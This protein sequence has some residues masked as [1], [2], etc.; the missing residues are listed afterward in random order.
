MLGKLRK[1]INERLPKTV[2]NAFSSVGFTPN[3]ATLLGLLFAFLSPVFAFFGLWFLVPVMIIL[4]GFMDIVDGAIARATGKKSRF[5][6]YLDSLTDRVSDT[7]FFLALIILGVN[8]YLALI[9]L[10]LSQ[11]VS[12][13]RSKGEL[14]GIKMEGVGLLERSERILLLFLA[15]IFPIFGL[16]LVS[17]VVVLVI[18]ILAA[19][20]ILQRSSAVKNKIRMEP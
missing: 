5:G 9:A 11:I 12:Y 15:S 19:I 14:L 1:Y 17:N 10:G 4:S 7:L 13:A 6:E 3:R 8:P 2:G 16:D 18:C 20:T